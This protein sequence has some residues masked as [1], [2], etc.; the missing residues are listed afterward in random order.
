V[1][2]P[3]QLNS[4]LIPTLQELLNKCRACQ[5]QRN[6]L[7]EQEAKERKIKGLPSIMVSVKQCYDF[8]NFYKI[9]TTYGFLT[10]EIKPFLSSSP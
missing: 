3:K 8:T 10:T 6:S 4:A 9:N 2:T 7:Q 5:Q 1:H